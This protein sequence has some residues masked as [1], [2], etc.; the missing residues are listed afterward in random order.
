MISP[1]QLGEKQLQLHTRYYLVTN[2]GEGNGT[3][4]YCIFF[5][6]T[7]RPTCSVRVRGT[8][9]RFL[10]ITNPSLFLE[11]VGDVGIVLDQISKLENINERGNV[12]SYTKKGI[13][14]GLKQ[15]LSLPILF[16]G[17]YPTVGITGVDLH[18][19]L[20][21]EESMQR[22]GAVVRCVT[23]TVLCSTLSGD[24]QFSI[25]E[26]FRGQGGHAGGVVVW[27]G[28]TIDEHVSPAEW[29][30]ENG[31][32]WEDAVKILKT[33][34][35]QTVERG[36]KE[37][38][39]PKGALPLSDRCFL[40]KKNIGITGPFEKNTAKIEAKLQFGSLL[41]ASSVSKGE[42]KEVLPDRGIM[43]ETDWAAERD[44]VARWREEQRKKEEKKT[45]QEKGKKPP[46][47]SPASSESSTLAS[48]PPP[49]APAPFK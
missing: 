22:E 33:L 13:K 34:G 37:G 38:T 21:P 18:Q 30:E 3:S 43:S 15:P 26:I 12:E 10:L 47:P 42:K 44:A 4:L 36:I 19:I 14:V 41:S 25:S 28:D 23:K 17:K 24:E 5:D 20:P 7:E 2:P 6:A 40:F 16:V 35:Y 11:D 45:E 32:S 31:V 49:P 48:T 8:D 29:F 46:E 9:Q 27:H 39:W 1:D